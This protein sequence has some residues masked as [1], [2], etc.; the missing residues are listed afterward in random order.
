MSL[1]GL[2]TIALAANV[3]FAVTRDRVRNGIHAGR[4]GAYLAV[5]MNGELLTVPV[6]DL[7]LPN[8]LAFG[9][10]AR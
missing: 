9:W 4:A 7:D 8:D 6:S 10:R 5:N 3:A 1:K 2:V